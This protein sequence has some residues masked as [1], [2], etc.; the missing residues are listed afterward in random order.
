[1]FCEV[2]SSSFLAQ[3]LTQVPAMIWHCCNS[4]WQSRHRM[5]RSNLK[6]AAAH[7][8]GVVSY[9]HA[10]WPVTKK[11]TFSPRWSIRINTAKLKSK[12]PSGNPNIAGFQFRFFK[13]SKILFL[14][15][16][17]QLILSAV[18]SF[19]TVIWKSHSF[20]SRF[21]VNSPELTIPTEAN[22]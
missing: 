22:K 17:L 10:N 13:A 3:L 6:S 14:F 4:S 20:Q 5:Q 2:Q 9:T 1:M 18:I 8:S 21:K 15:F 7:C 12:L 16:S 19:I 11:K